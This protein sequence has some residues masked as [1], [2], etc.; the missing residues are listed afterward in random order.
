MIPL[1]PGLF[2]NIALSPV[3]PSLTKVSQIPDDTAIVT[4]DLLKEQIE[5]VVQE[6]EGDE[7]FDVVEIDEQHFIPGEGVVLNHDIGE[8]DTDVFYDFEE[9][10]EPLVREGIVVTENEFSEVITDQE[11][12]IGARFNEELNNFYG[13]EEDEESSIG[14]IEWARQK[15]SEIANSKT[16]QKGVAFSKSVVGS[17]LIQTG[18]AM[19]GENV[20]M[21]VGASFPE[22]VVAYTVTKQATDSNKAGI[23]AALTLT[24]LS[25]S[26]AYLTGTPME[27]SQALGYMVTASGTIAGGMTGLETMGQEVPEGY[28]PR[29][30]AYLATTG[31]VGTVASGVSTVAEYVPLPL[32][33]TTTNVVGKVATKVAG[34]AAY[35]G[36]ESVVVVERMMNPKPSNLFDPGEFT[37][38]VAVNAN[39][40]SKAFAESMAK[41]LIESPLLA[42][43]TRLLIQH[44]IDQKV[45]TNAQVRAMN[46]FAQ[47]LQSETI[48]EKIRELRA[49][50]NQLRK[51]A[52]K[53]EIAEVVA[54]EY[55]ALEKVIANNVKAAADPMISTLITQITDL[56]AKKEVEYFGMTLS[57]ESQTKDL[58]EV[59]LPVLIPMIGVYT[60]R[61]LL[62]TKELSKDE[63]E[64][65]YGT[66]SAA[67]FAPY[68]EYMLGRG[69]QGLVATAIPFM[70]EYG[71]FLPSLL[72]ESIGQSMA[73]P[74][75]N[76]DETAPPREVPPPKQ[77]FIESILEKIRIIRYLISSG[78]LNFSNHL[79]A[80]TAVF[81]QHFMKKTTTGAE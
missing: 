62:E 2:F 69:M 81:I 29:T 44:N 21:M 32:V 18:K 78:L 40:D 70:Q 9:T 38:N 67:L 79:K 28:V 55:G 13:I 60:K 36:P 15:G 51:D 16:V 1:N 7:F 22:A 8:N 61:E 37:R 6:D 23:A 35:Y 41:K 4:P 52:L 26:L 56:M 45:S 72:S 20:G 30:A 48:Q 49:T 31:V 46:K 75:I 27:Y 74:V 12:Q 42:S 11:T 54:Q 80:A 25:T 5:I 66:I 68:N 50:P 58:L 57:N 64:S 76:F 33:S 53:N 14:W 43:I 65:F 77:S 59:L 19:I 39:G 73:D 34:T 17:K 10:E 3:I 47:H 71:Q 63:I 24:A